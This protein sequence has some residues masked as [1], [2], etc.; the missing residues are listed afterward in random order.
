VNLD[1]RLRRHLLAE[2]HFYQTVPFPKSDTRATRRAPMKSA[3]QLEK[4]PHQEIVA[5]RDEIKIV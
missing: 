1:A 2:I 5:A 3:L 4:L